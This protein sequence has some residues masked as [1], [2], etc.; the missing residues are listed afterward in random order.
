[1][2]E[3]ADSVAANEYVPVSEYVVRDPKVVE[4]MSDTTVELK[5]Q[6]HPDCTEEVVAKIG[7][8]SRNALWACK[9]GFDEWQAKTKPDKED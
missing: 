8:P 3:R 2:G 1:M 4:L 6:V 9:R 7:L 5:C